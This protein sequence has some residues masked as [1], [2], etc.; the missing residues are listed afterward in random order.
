MP[1]IQQNIPLLYYLM[2]SYSVRR[3]AFLLGKCY[4]KFSVNEVAC[5][6]GLPNRGREFHFQRSPLSKYKHN[7]LVQEIDSLTIEEASPTLEL[8]RVN[9]LV[10]Y[11]LAVLLFPLKGLKVPTCILEI[12]GLDDFGAVNWPMAIHS[13]LHS[14]FARM[15]DVAAREEMTNLGYLEGCSVILVVWFFEHTKLAAPISEMAVP[16]LHRWSPKISISA[17]QCSELQVKLSKPDNVRRALVYISVEEQDLLGEEEEVDSSDFEEENRRLKKEIKEREEAKEIKEKRDRVKK[18]K[19]KRVR[20]KK[21]MEEEERKREVVKEMKEEKRVREKKKREEEEKKR[22][23]RFKGYVDDLKHFIQ[24][25]FDAL[26][27]LFREGR[28]SASLL[29]TPPS[30]PPRSSPK[31]EALKEE[32]DEKALITYLTKTQTKKFTPVKGRQ[33]KRKGDNLGHHSQAITKYPGRDHLSPQHRDVIDFV[34]S[35]YPDRDSIVIERGN[36]FISR[37]SLLDILGTEWV[38][39]SHIDAYAY[40]LNSLI[41]RDGN[42]ML[43]F[44]FVSSNHAYY[45]RCGKISRRLVDH[46]THDSFGG[47]EAIMIPCH[48]ASHWV[49]LVGN[50]KGKYWDFYDSLPNPMH[51]SSLQEN[52]RFLHEDRAEVLPGDIIDWPIHTVEGLPTQDNGNDCGIF[53]MK[54]MEASLGKD[55]VDWTRHTSWVKEMPRIRA[56]IVATLLQTFQTSLLTENGFCV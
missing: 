10:R 29:Q 15:S 2:K 53:V 1:V 21:K 11:V 50:L 46:I 32:E 55:R 24:G 40:V 43:R 42:N 25:K 41:E 3:N 30:S 36:I 26:A 18:L 38:C 23:E 8:R 51:R 12:Q 17:T 45:K 19:E 7:D 35:R 56:E 28:P 54:Y 14:H 49:L 47:A 34:L 5:I 27:A 16:R 37:V 52:I 9:A 44:L 6:L 39:S 31:E 33:K 13:F 48:V 20:E 22:E 4:V